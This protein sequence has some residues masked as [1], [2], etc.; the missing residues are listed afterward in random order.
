MVRHFC[1]VFLCTFLATDPGV[2]APVYGTPASGPGV[3]NAKQIV[4]R[5]DS[6]FI[7]RIA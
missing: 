1:S 2:L 4:Q 7:F 6:D 5:I 3:L